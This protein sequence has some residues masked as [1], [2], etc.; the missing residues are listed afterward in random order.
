MDKLL[1]QE[2][3]KEQV[4]GLLKNH[5]LFYNNEHPHQELKWYVLS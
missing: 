5:F 2:Q 1:T 3:L 4:L